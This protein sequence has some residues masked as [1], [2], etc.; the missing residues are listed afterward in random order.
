[1]AYP[2]RGRSLRYIR[3]MS[4]PKPLNMLANSIA[5]YPA[6]TATIRRGVGKSGSANTSSDVMACSC[7]FTKQLWQE[8]RSQMDG[9]SDR[10]TALAVRLVPACDQCQLRTLT[11]TAGVGG[12]KLPAHAHVCM[13]TFAT[14]TD[15]PA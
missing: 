13:Q 12:M 5:M 1:M 6:P 10:L 2:A 14:I 8:Q 7:T 3:C 4:T 9:T 11:N 15:G